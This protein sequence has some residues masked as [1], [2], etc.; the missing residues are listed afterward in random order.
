MNQDGRLNL[1]AEL[2]LIAVE[3]PRQRHAFLESVI[4]I[5]A[6]VARDGREDSAAATIVEPRP[7]SL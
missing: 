2:G 4:G 6:E 3:L 5:V 7:Y 1:V